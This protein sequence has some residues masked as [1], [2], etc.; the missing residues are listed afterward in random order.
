[1]INTL[2]PYFV[3]LPFCAGV[4][5]AADDQTVIVTV[6]PEIMLDLGVSIND[7]DRAS[8]LITG[9]LV[10]Y[11]AAIPVMGR[12]ADRIGYREA[13]LLALGLFAIGSVLVAIS[14]TLA[15]WFGEED[16]AIQWM[17][18]AR[19]FQSVG[20]GAVIPIAIV[21]AGHLVP[22]KQHAVAF[23]LLGACAEGGAV[24]GPL[25]GGVITNISSWE[26]TF[27]LNLPPVALIAILVF[28]TRKSKLTEVKV[29]FV[30]GLLFTVALAALTLGLTALSGPLQ[31]QMWL[32]SVGIVAIAVMV[33]RQNR[34]EHPFL[35]RTVLQGIRVQSANA[36]QLLVG[37]ALI[38]GMVTI[39][40]MA[41]TVLGSSALEGG[42]YLLR[43]TLAIAVAALLGGAISQRYGARLPAVTGLFLVV[44]GY[45]AMSRWDNTIGDPWL[46]IHLVM[47]GSGFGL[48]IAPIT[49]S[50]LHYTAGQDWGARA[51]IVTLSRLIGMTLGLAALIAWGTAR[52]SSLTE[53]TPQISIDPESI[54]V[55]TDAAVNAGVIVFQG[56]FTAGAIIGIIALVPVVLMTRR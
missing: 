33:W 51:S 4:F 17:I 46:T 3:F 15:A 13:F 26:W 31:N 54:S 7:I 5:L 36:T 12:V 34:V 39:P 42:L 30:G 8:W 47:S 50:A 53:N 35:P 19:V 52:F 37:A 27:W 1:M 14:P 44:I 22:S 24:L 49:Q 16:Q 56:F 18:G 23:G 25:W 10:G 43:M 40:L 2:R 32:F 29:D 20:G 48:L 55:F 45:F 11:T 41:N 9:Y 28:K 6:L 21:A 38:I